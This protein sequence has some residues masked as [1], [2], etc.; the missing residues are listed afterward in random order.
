MLLEGLV[1]RGE[2]EE[3]V[4]DLKLQSSKRHKGFSFHPFLLFSAVQQRERRK[5][6]NYNEIVQSMRSSRPISLPMI[7]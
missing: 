7:L 5:D 1:V 6:E 2:G 4:M 3:E